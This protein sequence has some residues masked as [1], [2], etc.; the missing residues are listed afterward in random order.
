MSNF[1][2]IL[3]AVLPIFIFIEISIIYAYKK[4]NLKFTLPIALSA[5]TLINLI[6]HLLVEFSLYKNYQEFNSDKITKFYGYNY[7]VCGGWTIG[8]DIK[9]GIFKI[10]FT[11]ILLVISIINLM[12][13]YNVIKRIQNLFIVCLICF[14][15]LIP[16]VI[17]FLENFLGLILFKKLLFFLHFAPGGF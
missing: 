9:T 12:I 11:V 7:Y 17:C 5:L 8:F 1:I 15:P 14:I 6:S 4:Y 10:V 16:V 3:L 13:I 2:L